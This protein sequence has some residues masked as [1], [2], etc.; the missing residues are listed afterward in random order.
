MVLHI[1]ASLFLFLYLLLN[2]FAAYLA[3]GGL[4]Q[5]KKK[6]EM[7]RKLK[8]SKSKITAQ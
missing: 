3:L 2:L 4:Q 7:K 6:E 1:K 8:Q 5:E